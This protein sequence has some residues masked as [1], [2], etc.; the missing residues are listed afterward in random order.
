MRRFEIQRINVFKGIWQSIKSIKAAWKHLLLFTAIYI[1]VYFAI[2]LALSEIGFM[3]FFG[4]YFLSR[5]IL[6]ITKL[7]FI[8]ML[9]KIISNTIKGES[10][11]PVKVIRFVFSKIGLILFQV[12]ICCA[13]LVP[14]ALIILFILMSLMESNQNPITITYVLVG[15]AL[16]KIIFSLHGVIINNDDSMESIQASFSM[17]NGNFIILVLTLI[18]LWLLD[19]GTMH[20]I[21]NFISGQLYRII[22]YNVAKSVMLIIQVTL[23]TSMYHQLIAKKVIKKSEKHETL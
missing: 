17:T 13:F 15:I 20:F 22:G 16:V 11:S 7:L 10:D 8:I 4:G 6:N 2:T 23:L 14:S 3:S 9:I 1:A 5:M 21:D 12:M 18:G 19:Y